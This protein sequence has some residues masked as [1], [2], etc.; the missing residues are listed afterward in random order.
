M[1]VT[2]DVER[3]SLGP[4]SIGREIGRGSAGIVYKAHDPA[5]NRTVALRVLPTYWND[6]PDFFAG[7]RREVAAAGRL[8]HAHIMGVYDVGAVGDTHY[9]TTEYLPGWSLKDLLHETEGPL[10]LPYAV[11]VI[12]E[13][14]SALHYAHGEGQLHLDVRPANIRLQ[15]GSS[16]SLTD[17]GVGPALHSGFPLP[18]GLDAGTAEYMAPEQVEGKSVDN[19]TD[20]Y[21]LGV[22]AF[23]VLTGQPPFTGDTRASILTQQAVESP[24][25]PR[26]LN[27]ELPIAVEQ[28]VLRALAKLPE[29]RYQ[30]ASEFGRALAEAAAPKVAPRTAT[31]AAPPRR[32]PPRDRRTLVLVGGGLI[33][34]SGLG[35]ALRLRGQA[36][37]PVVATTATA[38]HTPA[39]PTI[40][41]SPS[42]TA[43]ATAS[44][45]PSRTARPPTRTRT[46]TAVPPTPT[47]TPTDTVAPTATPTDTWTPQP[48]PTQTRRPPTR[49][50]TRP[51]PPTATPVPTDTAVPT[52]TPEPT[53]PPPPPTQ[54]P[55]P[56]TSTPHPR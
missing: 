11:R 28:A 9:V 5:L 43:S 7:Y 1:N 17:F 6:Y 20:I 47:A 29:E 36:P 34:L 25:S 41:P 40:Q 3:A 24:P 12:Q 10:A 35:I 8:K 54:P 26:Q 27:P 32:P 51:P 42:H 55:P 14:A 21:A 38:T 56:P 46:R 31:A 33:L 15:L 45:T 19:R 16:T 49:T 22:V 48:V 53:Q 39:T 50:S 30:R 23:E 37:L 2:H 13:I 18:P 44:S 52:S 4:Y